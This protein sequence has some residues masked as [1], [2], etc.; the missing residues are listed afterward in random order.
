MTQAVVVRDDLNTTRASG[1]ALKLAKLS[2]RAK[3]EEQLLAILNNTGI[4][5]KEVAVA[6]L[7]NPVLSVVLANIAI[8]YAQTI[9]I[10]TGTEQ[11]LVNVPDPNNPGM[12]HHEYKNVPVQQ[13]LLSQALATTMESV[14]NTAAVIQSLGGAGGI[15]GL[16]KMFVK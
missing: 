9:K 14:I 1:A 7:N 5:I 12:G 15:A 8:E 10:T 6:A 13:P 2:A 3:R 11:R 16:L 4:G